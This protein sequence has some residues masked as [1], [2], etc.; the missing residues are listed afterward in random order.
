MAS[1]LRGERFS[2]CFVRGDFSYSSCFATCLTLNILACTEEVAEINCSVLRLYFS[3]PQVA[4]LINSQFLQR[5]ALPRNSSFGFQ[6]PQPTQYV[7]SL[8][9]LHTGVLFRLR[10]FI[11]EVA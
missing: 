4:H 9:A 1:S 2:M 6:F 11:V 8:Q 10:F 3:S 5:L 7:V